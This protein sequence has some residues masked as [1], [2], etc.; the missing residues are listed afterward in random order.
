M[1]LQAITHLPKN[2]FAFVTRD[3]EV[4]IRLQTSS[5]VSRVEIIYGDK[6]DW[7]ATVS[8]TEM[9][10][11][12]QDDLFTYWY[13]RLYCPVK[14]V[15]YGFKVYGPD[16]VLWVKETGC[17]TEPINDHMELFDFPWIHVSDALTVSDWVREAIF[18]QIFPDRFANGDKGNDP[19]N[20]VSWDSNPTFNSFY[21][22]DLQGIIDNLDYLS[23]LGITAIYLTPIFSASSNHKYDTIDYKSIDPHFG[24]LSTFKQLVNACHSKGIKVILDAVFNHIGWYSPQ[25]QDVL[26]NGPK[27]RY[28]NW[29]NIYDFPIRTHPRPNYEC[30]AFV[31]SMPKLN[32]VNPEVREFLLDVAVYWIKEANID[33]WRLDVA[34]EVDHQFW[35]EFRNRVKAIKPD[36]YIV[37][38]IT[39]FAGPWLQGDQFDGVMNYRLTQAIVDFVAEGK[40]N[41]KEFT[42]RLNKLIF[43]YQ[44]AASEGNL[45]LLGSHDTPR[46]LTRCMGNKNLLK[47]AAMLMFSL[48][49]APCIYYGDEVGMEGGN[50]PDCRRGMVWDN[51]KQDR[52]LLDWFRRLITVRKKH[53]AFSRGDI[54]VLNIGNLAA[55]KRLWQEEEYLILVNP[56]LQVVEIDV[57]QCQGQYLDLLGGDKVIIDKSFLVKPQKGLILKKLGS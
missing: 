30:F 15:T 3:K 31:A 2:N 37:G 6:Y 43:Y 8:K 24:D 26:K 19:E 22:G 27:S 44:R 46:F 33:G 28:V 47:L 9:L 7:E 49:G 40:I 51:D 55:F 23:S 5:E 48:P 1:L 57:T 21:G 10:I 52:E 4:E 12:G 18:Y 50:D 38:E 39:Y 17:T 29:F 13:C 34:N 35:R 53:F 25:F 42:Y 36:A 54:K 16:Q 41:G 11:L 14:R 32:T 45:N 20:L 56:S